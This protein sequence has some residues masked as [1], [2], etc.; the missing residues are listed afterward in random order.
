[1]FQLSSRV[2]CMQGIGGVNFFK[3]NVIGS[4]MDKSGGTACVAV[5]YLVMLFVTCVLRT[6]NLLNINK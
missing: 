2:T 3:L 5:V 4:T 1:M 6:N